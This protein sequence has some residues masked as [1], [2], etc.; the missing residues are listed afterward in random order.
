[1]SVLS[2]GDLSN[3]FQIRRQ[4]TALKQSLA[5]L[6]TEL[7]SGQKQDIGAAL[8]GDFGPFAGINHHLKTLGAFKTA[9]SEAATLLSATQL[10]MAQI[11]D[12]GRDLSPALLTA[13]SAR[14]GTLI[15][16]TAQDAR[17]KLDM[18][19]AHLNTRI[20]NR[21]LLAGAA[22][23]R[24]A[25]APGSVIMDELLV[26]VAGETTAAGIAQA[27]ED[28]FTAPGGGF[29][30]IA[31][32]GATTHSG[33][34]AISP[35]ETVGVEMRADDPAFRSMLQS[36]ALSGLI[37]EGV[38]DG[39]ISQQAELTARAA[40]GLLLADEALTLARADVGAAQARVETATARNAAEVTAHELMRAELVGADPYQ[41]A[42]E[43]EAV[44]SQIETLYTVTAR[45]A[46]LRFTDFMR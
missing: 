37:A 3:T 27:V 38:L 34:V 28:W 17:Q 21:T 23:D 46:G 20:A 16:S 22:T 32:L 1:M 31:Y 24:A 19:A 12:A 13:S 33:P 43:L 9:T 15:R 29:E 40:E 8:G 10:T 11:Q 18:V 44:Y 35:D 42:T 14:D 4:T 26:A 45:I 2:V 39:D 36:L 30:T 5:R 41:T 7:A 25:M 6:G